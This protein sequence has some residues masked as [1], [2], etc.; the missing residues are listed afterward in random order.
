MTSK[1]GT[2]LSDASAAVA[3]FVKRS[4]GHDERLLKRSSPWRAFFR[5]GCK[6]LFI[7]DVALKPSDV[8]SGEDNLL[9]APVTMSSR[10][11]RRAARLAFNEACRP[12]GLT[13]SESRAGER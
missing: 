13:L 3:V 6:E 12:A 8:F 9:S 4:T 1:F 10:A 2:V 7:N 11:W 5:S